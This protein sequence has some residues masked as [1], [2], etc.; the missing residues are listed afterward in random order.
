MQY[1]LRVRQTLTAT[2]DSV[3]AWNGLGS[4]LSGLYAQFK[5]PASVF[6]TLT[7]A[8]Y[9]SCLALLHIT[10]P[11]ILSVEG[12]NVSVP[13]PVQTLGVPEFNNSV[14]TSATVQFLN[15]AISFLPWI[16]NLESSQKIGLCNGSLY[17]TLQELA[18]GQGR[19]RVNAT[20][21][22][23][24]CGYLPGVNSGFDSGQWNISLGSPETFE[25]NILTTS[26]GPNVITANYM[27]DDSNGSL[28][29][30]TPNN[31]VDSHGRQG[32][33]VELDPPMNYCITHL[34]FLQCWRTLVPQEGIVD[35]ESG[36]L[37]ESSVQPSV[38]KTRSTWHQYSNT[39]FPPSDST[40]LGG[41]W[42]TSLPD[43]E[44][45]PTVILGNETGATMLSVMDEFLMELLDLDPSWISTQIVPVSTPALVL[46]DIENA[47][48]AFVATAFW[49]AGHVRADRLQMLYTLAGDTISGAELIVI[50]PTL[51][52]GHT[53]VPQNSLRIRLKVNIHSHIYILKKLTVTRTQISLITVS[54]GL[55][56]SILLGIVALPYAFADSD[57]NARPP[58]DS[59]SI[60]QTIWI[61]RR[62]DDLSNS[63]PQ[64]AVPEE[65]NL[66]TAGLVAV[67]LFG[68]PWETGFD[69]ST[70]NFH[71]RSKLFTSDPGSPSRS[72]SSSQRY[73]IMCISLHLGLVILHLTL[74]AIIVNSH[75][76]H[77]GIFSVQSQ[78]NV[79]L[80]I[81][82]IST[83]IGTIYLAATLY[84]TQT[85]ALRKCLGSSQTLT[86]THDQTLSWAGIGAA[87]SSLLAQ[88]ALPADIIGTLAITGYLAT[89]LTLH[90][91]TP[92][93][94]AV[95]TFNHTV[96]AVVP[97]Q[98]FPLWNGSDT[99]ASSVFP[100]DLGDFL[101]WMS[102]LVN[103][104]KTVGLFNGSLYDILAFSSSATTYASVSATG[105]NVT[106]G[107]LNNV[108]F[109]PSAKGSLEDGLPWN[110]TLPSGFSFQPPNSGPNI[111]TTRVLFDFGL[112][113]TA[114][115]SW[116]SMLLYTTNKVVDSTGNTGL[117]VGIA[118]P[119]GPNSTVSE[120]Q[121]LQ[122]SRSLIAQQA[123]VDPYS[124]LIIPSSLKPILHKTS[125]QWNPYEQS[126]QTADSNH[127]TT[128][129]NSEW[130]TPLHQSNVP[131]SIDND[132]TLILFAW[133][134]L[135][136]ME[137]LG[138]DPSWIQSGSVT[139]L[140]PVLYLHDIENALSSLLASY[141]WMVGH[142]RLQPLMVK[143]GVDYI[144]GA[145]AKRKTPVLTDSN[146]SVNQM[147]LASRLNI[148]VIA[149]LIGL[150]A[151]VL[152]FLLSMHFMTLDSISGTS[153]TGMGILQVIWLFRNHPWL[154]TQL[155]QVV[156][157]TNK[158][159]RAAGMIRVQLVMSE[160][161][162]TEMRPLADGLCN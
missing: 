121:L 60:L 158:A 18:P 110:I 72:G 13:V 93:L 48:S 22:N 29:V 135:Y 86:A 120:L 62:H 148:N 32:Y 100:S 51:V 15:S 10:S 139:S 8:V 89:I 26:Y 24:T 46:H 125:S 39:S 34:Q 94:F 99:N 96:P 104:S 74:L 146:T 91:S 153:L 156:E 42:W 101:Q 150:S 154:S 84:V 111:L 141:F 114:P 103:Q 128:L 2:H 107:Y 106:C 38:H 63:L 152:C 118:P 95:E 44:S 78:H 3:A 80:W 162:A 79:S 35:G 54:I 142:I 113:P 17:D 159:L 145:A 138:L 126:P 50:P 64:V 137:A 14:D 92:A 102:S 19:A 131:M 27:L 1:N 136:I 58:M 16:D 37:V 71:T 105:F 69:D 59:I 129:V 132:S 57:S 134:D 40:L 85:L 36:Q 11:A 140:P 81:T 149:L 53:I 23:I 7:A 88:L 109:A 21:F 66:R 61:L 45:G 108:S 56:V 68:P 49:L 33:P 67:Q 6:G 47:I 73:K 119:M 97:T 28:I 123:Q 43:L 70:S 98:G 130:P 127:I 124:K 55:G 144:D 12:F 76:E 133:M 151:S 115:E 117:P 25:A 75:A 112:A 155:E 161:E 30:S 143:Y 157:P 87:F 4:A 9:L 20:A 147:Q 41:D 82:L 90:V 5:V 52:A 83:A 122:C 65:T 116:P 31:V 77:A 160:G